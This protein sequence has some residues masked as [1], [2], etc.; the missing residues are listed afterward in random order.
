MTT[1]EAKPTADKGSGRGSRRSGPPAQ[2]GTVVF[3]VRIGGRKTPPAPPTDEP[4]VPVPP[5]MN[6][7][8]D[9]VL[10]Q[11]QVQRLRRTFVVLGVG[12]VAAV[13]ALWTVQAGM[14]AAAEE[15]LAEE[16]ARSAEASARL[17]ALLPIQTF[18]ADIVAKEA[19]IERAMSA[20]VLTSEILEE[21]AP[22]GPGVVLDDITISLAAPVTAATAADPSAATTGACVSPDPFTPSTQQS[23]CVVVSGV[24]SSRVALSQWILDVDRKDL[25][26]EVFVPGTTSESEAG[27]V[28]FTASLGL[29]SETSL[30]NRYVGVATITAKGA[31]Q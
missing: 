12:V 6:L 22:G 29:D 27:A 8:P 19:A 13:A 5:T 28:S 31:D 24:A 14:I 21:V 2:D 1:L 18:Y 10:E 26:T 11:A 4:F 7:L 17:Q 16:E 23:G 15:R 9:S 30:S 20:E 25:F 3:G